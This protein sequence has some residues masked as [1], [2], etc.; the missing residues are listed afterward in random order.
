MNNYIYCP[1]FNCKK[2][3]EVCFHKCLMRFR[4]PTIKTDMDQIYHEIKWRWEKLE[5]EG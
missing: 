5:D 2:P 1:K 4:C 3:E